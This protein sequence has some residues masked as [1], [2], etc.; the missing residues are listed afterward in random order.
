M[1]REWRLKSVARPFLASRQQR[2]FHP[3]GKY[4]RGLGSGSPR[5][6]LNSVAGVPIRY[7]SPIMRKQ[8]AMDRKEAYAARILVAIT[9]HFDASRLRFLAE[10][11]RALAEYPVQSM[12]VVILTNTSRQEEL[13]LLHGLCGETLSEAHTSVRSYC[14]LADPWVLTWCHKE[15]I[16]REF[17]HDNAGRYTHFIYLESDIRLTFENFCYFVEFR[18]ALRG[19]GL[20][21]AFLRV[22][23]CTA[24]AGFT[25]SDLFWPVYV[26]LQSYVRLGDTAFVNVPNPYNP[27][28]ILDIELAAEYIPSRSFR[29]EGSYEVCRWGVAERAAMGLCLENV[30]AP[31]QSRYVVPVSMKDDTVPAFARVAHLPNNYADNPKMPL[32]KVRIG[33]LFKGARALREGAWWPSPHPEHAAAPDRYFLVTHHDTIVYFDNATQRIRH[34]PLGIAPLNLAGELVSGSL[35]FVLT[36]ADPP[37]ER[38]VSFVDS[39]GT[40]GFAEDDRSAEL[41]VET[42]ADCAVGL[43]R[44]DRYVAADLDGLV[45]NDRAWC[46]AFEQFRLVRADTIAGLAILQHHTWISACDGVAVTLAPQPIDYGRERPHESSAIAATLAAGALDRRREIVFGAA[47]IRLVNLA[48]QIVFGPSATE[49]AVSDAAGHVQRFC[50]A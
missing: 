10:V 24:L 16:A 26:P 45:R 13:G 4:H 1:S 7:W 8:P 29:L 27:F 50:R 40:I 5:T 43:R 49:V 15:I 48:R 14:E 34:L 12:E 6:A 2:F 41:T 42:F 19:F 22:E 17:V 37:R 18:E 38:L 25:A 33:S 31:F 32:G 44:G 9:F 35:R 47:R 30:P 36:R 28:Y 23:Y 3:V 20:L 21:P 46:R 39:D 11:L